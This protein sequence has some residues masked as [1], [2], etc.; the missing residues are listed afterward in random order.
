[1]FHPLPR[2][3]HD[4]ARRLPPIAPLFALSGADAGQGEITM[5]RYYR[6]LLTTFLVGALTAPAFAQTPTPTAPTAEAASPSVAAVDKPVAPKHESA[7]PTIHKHRHIAKAKTA[8]A[9]GSAKP[10]AMAPPAANN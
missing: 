5:P 3:R 6:A 7:K 1:M 8:A 4:F 2:C 9:T 10:D